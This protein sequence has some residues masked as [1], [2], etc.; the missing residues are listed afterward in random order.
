MFESI[1]S[2]FSSDNVTPTIFVVQNAS[3]KIKVYITILRKQSS[4]TETKRPTQEEVG[5]NERWDGG[6]REVQI[7][8]DKMER[9]C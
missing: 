3:N 8:K 1:S 6:E 2:P 4:Q 5:V 7:T 9:V